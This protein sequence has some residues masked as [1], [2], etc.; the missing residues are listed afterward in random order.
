MSYFL[1][2]NKLMKQAA[3]AI[4]LFT[5]IASPLAQPRPAL[6]GHVLSATI[7]VLL[8]QNTAYADAWLI[9]PLA[10]ALSA[11]VMTLTNTVHPPGGA[12]AVLAVV[13]PS[14]RT[15]GW[16]FVALV[17]L[18]TLLMIG[19]ASL[20]ANLCG[21]R[22]P[23]WWWSPYDTGARWR[24]PPVGDVDVE[25]QRVEVLEDADERGRIISSLVLGDGDTS[26][27][28]IVSAHGTVVGRDVDILPEERA[29]L[30]RIAARL[31]AL[32]GRT[33][34]E[35]SVDNESVDKEH[36]TVI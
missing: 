35:T 10:C 9:A 21:R 20:F 4:L 6:L 22:Y 32:D 36:A 34:S 28:L 2:R 29:L 33:N 13:D 30:D 12:A 1:L 8:A 26:A 11:T 15:L 7:G 19:T 27:T 14:A 23:V 25:G 18:S 31:R 17:G 3:S 5:S 24:R 16:N